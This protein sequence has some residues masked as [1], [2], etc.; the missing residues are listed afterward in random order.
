MRALM[1][2]GRVK[3]MSSSGLRMSEVMRRFRSVSICSGGGA[4]RREE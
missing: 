3:P 2:R 4:V 1:A